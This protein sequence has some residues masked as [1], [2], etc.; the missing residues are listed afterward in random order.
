M[1][2]VISLVSG[3]YNRLE[4]LIRMVASARANLP[5]GIPYE[6]ILVDGG[7][8]DG[9]LLWAARQPDI[10]VIEH[11]ELLGAIRAFCDGARAATGDYVLLANDDVLF[12]AGSI[13]RAL[14]HLEEHPGCG[15][16]AFMDNRPLPGQPPEERGQF[17]AQ[18]MT[19]RNADD[20][21]TQV[22]YAQVG[23]F[24]RALGEVCGWWGDRDPVMAQARTYGGD[25]YLSARIWEAGYTVDL[26][27]GVQCE[28]YVL[29]DGL[30]ELNAHYDGKNSPYYQRYPTGPVLGGYPLELP[31]ATPRLR[32]LYMPIYEPGY[33]QHKRTKRGLRNALAKR[34]LVYEWDYLNRGIVTGEVT[35]FAPHLI[36]TQFH[37]GRWLGV[38]KKIRELCPAAT[39]VNWCGDARGLT[40]PAYLKLLKEVD[41]QLVVN[42]AALPLYGAMGIPA[43]YWQ[44]GYEDWSTPLPAVPAHD[45]VFLANAYSDERRALE[46][47]LRGTGLDV[48]LYGAHW[49]RPD[50][51]CLYDFDTGAALY[52][53]AK[54]SVSD[55]FHDGKT[56]VRAFVSNR[57]FQAL[58]AGAFLL[59]QH[60]EAL[61]TFTGLVA[62]EHYVE[63]RTPSELVDLIG[64]Y[65]NKPDERKRI[66]DAG[67]AFVL[68]HYSF[69]EQV[70]KLFVEIL[71]M[72][73][74]DRATA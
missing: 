44:I 72:L 73:E 46:P 25:N 61:Q 53:T 38:L 42:A 28:D 17:K 69:D 31:A 56:P 27:E 65:V 21:P 7:S 47:L 52:R 62:G 32:V 8:D 2:P 64:Y 43:A 13:M 33:P 54:I 26:V 9:T 36:L 45:V 22:V 34:A 39:I 24:R 35:A 67:C 6:I 40:D 30:R 63:W 3:T 49:A 55:T 10:R 20:E 15:A 60:S 51:D 58:A 57:V 12:S 18:T 50:G 74:A 4:S 70:R 11:G 41:L 71:P 19:A 66:A 5:P 29:D 1:T 68:E 59:Q 14:I 23:L 16:V 37:D 48:G